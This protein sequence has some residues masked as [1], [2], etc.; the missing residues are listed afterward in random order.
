MSAALPY[1]ENQVIWMPCKE[2]QVIRI[3]MPRRL[4]QSQIRAIYWINAL[5]ITQYSIS[6]AYALWTYSIVFHIEASDFCL[7]VNWRNDFLVQGQGQ[8]NPRRTQNTNCD[9][10]IAWQNLRTSTLDLLYQLHLIQHTM[11]PALRYYHCQMQTR[12]REI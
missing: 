10:A 6:W 4:Y 9:G 11:H 1:K 7:K 5:S 2:N 8:Y 3:C 12:F